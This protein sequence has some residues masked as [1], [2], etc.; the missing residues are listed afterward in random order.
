MSSWLLYVFILIMSFLCVCDPDHLY[1]L[2][3]SCV[4]YIYVC[5]LCGCHADEVYVCRLLLLLCEDYYFLFVSSSTNSLKHDNAFEHERDS[6]APIRTLLQKTVARRCLACIFWLVLS[7]LALH[8]F[9]ICNE[10]AWISWCLALFCWSH[11]LNKYLRWQHQ[12]FKTQKT[13]APPTPG[14]E[15]G[16]PWG[17]RFLCFSCCC[18]VLFCCS[19]CS[20]V[21]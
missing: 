20:H 1:V 19:H 8:V 5:S 9:T 2:S 6:D 15:E 16:R 21:N 7:L 10:K 12:S 18:F 4:L 3:C 17:G 14:L 13:T 11:V